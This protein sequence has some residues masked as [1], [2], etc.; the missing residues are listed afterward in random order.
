MSLI[1]FQKEFLWDFLH[2]K[3]LKG[4]PIFPRKP[5][6]IIVSAANYIKI[7]NYKSVK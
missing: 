1:L 7:S 4:M 5:P 2:K 3:G 6:S